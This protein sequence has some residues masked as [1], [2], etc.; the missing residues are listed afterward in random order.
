MVILTSVVQQRLTGVG[1]LRR[2]L[3]SRR[4]VPGS[5][6]M[7]RILEDVSGGATSTAEVAFRRTCRAR[8]LPT[9]R[10]QVRRSAD[11]RRRYTD[12]EFRLPDGRLVIVEIDGVAHMDVA[13]WQDDI[14]RQNALAATAGAVVLRVTSW[15]LR[16]DPDP[17]F[18]L[19]A[20]VLTGSM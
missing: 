19:L 10:M 13:N 8:G 7:L 9:P 1:A 2:E 6:A 5:Q 17:F 11:G 20:R 18:D 3:T 15:E 14:E 12:A 4:N 16:E